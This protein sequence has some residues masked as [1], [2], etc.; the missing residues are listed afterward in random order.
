MHVEPNSPAKKAGLL[1]G[2]VIVGFNNLPLG[3]IEDLQKFLTPER[4]GVR[5]QLTILRNN[6]KLVIDIIPEESARG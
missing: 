4:V 5:S 1:Q 3:G 2:D 6:R